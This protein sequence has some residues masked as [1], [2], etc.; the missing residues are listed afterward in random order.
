LLCISLSCFD[1]KQRFRI[2]MSPFCA[3]AGPDDEERD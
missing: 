3:S 1:V 2:P